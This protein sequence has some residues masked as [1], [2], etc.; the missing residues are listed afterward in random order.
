[1]NEPELPDPDSKEDD[2]AAR[3]DDWDRAFLI[4]SAD[5]MEGE[6]GTPGRQAR[7]HDSDNIAIADES[8]NESK[9]EDAY[10]IVTFLNCVKAEDG[11][12]LYEN[13]DPGDEPEADDFDKNQQVCWC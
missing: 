10:E 6:T 1:M 2:D 11:S 8:D 12:S 7:G 5:N 9:D 3:D 4:D 13:L